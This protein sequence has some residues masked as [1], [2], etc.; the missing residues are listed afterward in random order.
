MAKAVADPRNTNDDEIFQTI[1]AHLDDDS[2]PINSVMKTVKGKISQLLKA[3]LL[4]GRNKLFLQTEADC[5]GFQKRN[6]PSLY[7]KGLT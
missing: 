6:L 3:F 4:N 7:L 1:K 2:N 5:K